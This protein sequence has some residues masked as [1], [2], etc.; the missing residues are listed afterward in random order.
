MFERAAHHALEGLDD[1]VP[2]LGDDTDIHVFVATQNDAVGVE[3]ELD[4]FLIIHQVEEGHEVQENLTPSGAVGEVDVFAENEIEGTSLAPA[5][6]HDSRS[7]DE[8]V[9]DRHLLRSP[10]WSP[11]EGMRL[12]ECL[13]LGTSVSVVDEVLDDIHFPRVPDRRLDAPL[14]E[15]IAETDQLA[16]EFELGNLPFEPLF[17]WDPLRIELS[18]PE[19]FGITDCHIILS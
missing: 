16:L 1:G 3:Q 13:D 7:I 5:S 15:L 4:L 2:F 12:D 8:V 19:D 6:G 18:S 10:Y 9:E 14:I 17:R 11:A